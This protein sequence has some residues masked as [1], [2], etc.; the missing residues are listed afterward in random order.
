MLLSNNPVCISYYIYLKQNIKT[1]TALSWWDWRDNFVVKLYKF[2]WD[3]EL[4]WW[5]V[6]TF[7]VHG[8]QGEVTL[9]RSM[10]KDNNNNPEASRWQNIFGK[11]FHY[12]SKCS[13]I[14]M[15]FEG[16][17]T[18][19]ISSLQTVYFL[20]LKAYSHRTL[21]TDYHIFISKWL[22]FFY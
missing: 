10:G 5:V 13:K 7:F 22:L 4:K 9:L 12:F 18:C 8:T 6:W 15:L 3:F 2:L 16:F 14:L 17:C 19:I 21:I 11:T 1:S 20:H